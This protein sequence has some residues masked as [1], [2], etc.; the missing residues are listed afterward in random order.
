MTQKLMRTYEQICLD[1][2][3]ELGKAT[4]REWAEAMGYKNP[5]ALSKVIRRILKTMPEK[6][7]VHDRKPRVYEAL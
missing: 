5:N 7:K 6:I 3:K 4:A 2:L 1:K